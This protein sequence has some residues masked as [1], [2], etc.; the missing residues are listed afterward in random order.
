[1]LVLNLKSKVIQL[2]KEKGFTL[3][4]V[5]I[6]ILVTAVVS[7][8]TTGV[9][10]TNNY[11]SDNGVS[12]S[13]LLADDNLK[14][15]LNV[16]SSIAT[17]YY[18]DVDK[19]AM[20]D[21]AISSMLNYLG[22][23]YTTYLNTNQSSNLSEKL[24]GSYKGIGVTITDRKI[25]SVTKNSPAESAGLQ[26]GDEFVSINGT[27]VSNST[28]EQIAS[29]IKDQ[30][31]DKVTIVVNRN[32]EQKT[33]E[34]PITS[35]Y[36]PAVTSKMIDNSNIG[37]IYISVFSDT[38]T[39]QVKDAMD[40]LK[41]QGMEKLI[42]DVRDDSGGYLAGAEGIASLFLEKGKII[43]SLE[44]KVGASVF[45]DK[46]DDKETMPIVILINK[47]SASASEI[48]AAALIDSYG[49]KTVGETSY[50]KG[51]VQQT[52]TLSDGSMAKYTSARWLRPNGECIDGEGITP[53][54]IVALEETKDEN[55]NVT[56]VVDTQLNKAIE[57]L[58]GTN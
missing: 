18:E 41:S 6:I 25:V 33:F 28:S 39:D 27:D 37:Y 21:S 24:D 10:V 26:V 51:K 29:L 56:N 36:V 9:I 14:E 42:I 22:D 4:N 11:K 46:T 48:L 44:N 19:K 13:E 17:N 54:Y 55:G 8:V 50:G 7:A 30:N 16:Y 43:Y 1:V 15:F 31:L 32:G 57:V 53:D 12:Y 5:I 2:K 23:N 58:N 35:L 49:A 38:I 3:L 47:S 52:V 45:K 34:I 40:D 20:M